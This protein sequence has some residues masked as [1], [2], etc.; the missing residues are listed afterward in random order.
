MTPTEEAKSINAYMESSFRTTLAGLKDA[1]TMS[2]AF[3]RLLVA[4]SGAKY[5]VIDREM[6]QGYRIVLQEADIDEA[7]R[8]LVSRIGARVA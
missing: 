7:V 3:G 5:D 1:A 4:M 2:F 8:Y 6:P